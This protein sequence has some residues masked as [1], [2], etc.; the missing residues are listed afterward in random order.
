MK[1]V[2]IFCILIAMSVTLPATAGQYYAGKGFLHTS[3]ATTL[4]PGALD[5]SFFAR[6]FVSVGSDVVGSISNGSSA[7]GAAFGFTRHSE[8]GFS[9]VLYQDLNATVRVDDRNVAT[10]IPGDTYIRLK[11]SGYQIGDNFMYGFA[12]ALRYR[13]SQFH[14]VHLEPYE[15]N[16]IE[17]ELVALL[18]YFEKPL[19]PDEGYS[20]HANIGILH[21]ND[22]ESPTDAAVSLNFLTSFIIPNPRFDYGAE[23]YGSFFMVRPPEFVLGREN[24]VYVTPMVR[25]KLFKGLHFTM[26]LDI[27]ALGHEN[28]TINTDVGYLDEYPNYST[29]RL[30]GRIHFTPSTAFYV[31]PTFKRVDERG[32]GRERHKTLATGPAAMQPAAGGGG[33][34][35]SGG[36][37]YDRQE[38]FRWAIEERFG[39]KEAVDVD[40]E[41][42]RKERMRAE[43]QLK[44]L[45]KELEAKNRKR[46]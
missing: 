3:T 2:V 11:V 38:L 42:I 26:G 22:T 37:M 40:L 35:V 21:H 44:K 31:A 43:E 14:D 9:Q 13:V 19:Y 20:V 7:M 27:L 33:A 5:V 4:P 39:G 41:K 30:T 28:T 25:Y 16:G 1:R 32:T 8:I 24:W 6:A 29:W 18:S 46:K 17:A 45:K 10:A 34:A 36:D 23:L 15:S 12:P